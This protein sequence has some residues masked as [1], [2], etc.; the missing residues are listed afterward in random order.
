MYLFKV[1]YNFAN[2]LV[3]LRQQQFF[4]SHNRFF[5]AGATCTKTVKIQVNGLDNSIFASDRRYGCSSCSFRLTYISVLVLQQV[6]L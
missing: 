1:S 2:F 3:Q 6:M 5:V 4:L